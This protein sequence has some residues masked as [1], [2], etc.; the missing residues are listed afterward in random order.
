M[1]SR[2]RL[3][4]YQAFE[5]AFGK[6]S[7]RMLPGFIPRKVWPSFLTDLERGVNSKKDV[8]PSKLEDTAN[9]CLTCSTFLQG[10]TRKLGSTLAPYAVE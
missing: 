5:A 6:S 8:W 3:F 9:S 10:G 2:I 7:S 1:K 4:L